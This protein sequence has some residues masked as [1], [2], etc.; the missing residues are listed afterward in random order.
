MTLQG[1]VRIVFY[2]HDDAAATPLPCGCELLRRRQRHV[3]A[4][5]LCF[6][7]CFHTSFVEEGPCVLRKADVDMACH[8]KACKVFPS[9]FEVGLDLGAPPRTPPPSTPQTTP[10]QRGD[11]A[12]PVTPTASSETGSALAGAHS[13]RQQPFWRLA[14][15]SDSEGL[16]ERTRAMRMLYPLLQT[17]S[18]RRS[19]SA[20][21][22]ETVSPGQSP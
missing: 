15:P 18:S 21:L 22:S 11:P 5:D 14:P 4:D 20:Q 10:T 3:A 6:F 2:D 17:G 12:W 1:D 9:D 7:T 8:D 13:A 16:L 19:L